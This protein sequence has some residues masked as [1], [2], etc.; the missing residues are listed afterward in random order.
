MN[1]MNLELCL[2]IR[3]TLPLTPW[4][5][6]FSLLKKAQPRAIISPILDSL[7]VL[8]Y[9]SPFLGCT[10]GIKRF[11]YWKITATK[12]CCEMLYEA[13]KHYNPFYYNPFSYP[14]NK[15]QE[16]SLQGTRYTPSHE[17]VSRDSDQILSSFLYSSPW[18]FT[19][20]HYLYKWPLSSKSSW[21]HFPLMS[22]ITW[23]FRN[24]LSSW[25]VCLRVTS[26]PKFW[27]RL[28]SSCNQ[29]TAS[30]AV[31]QCS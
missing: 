24:F 25:T 21:P 13:K 14:L 15:P 1:H 2:K 28:S 10:K 26:G 6:T 18:G 31:K 4:I 9:C 17:E 22:S 30:A 19:G 16:A 20:C 7:E 11:L 27:L 23:F 3:H 12:D 8:S 5:Y 29:S